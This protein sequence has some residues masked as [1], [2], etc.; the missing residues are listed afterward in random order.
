MPFGSQSCEDIGLSQGYLV[1][2]PSPM[3]FGSQSC[4]D[5]LGIIAL[6]SHEGVTN[7]FRQSVL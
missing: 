3:P 2:R 5:L 4:E 7:A 6:D 1:T